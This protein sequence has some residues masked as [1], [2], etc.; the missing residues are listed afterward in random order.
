MYFNVRRRKQRPIAMMYS[1]HLAPIDHNLVND[2]N[3][4]HHRPNTKENAADQ[5]KLKK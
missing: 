3:D 2:S 4:I 5:S 1:G